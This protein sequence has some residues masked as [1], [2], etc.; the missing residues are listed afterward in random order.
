MKIGLII[1]GAGSSRRYQSKTSKLFE[2]IDGQP[3]LRHTYLAFQN[4]ATIQ[5]TIITL[6][7]DH[8]AKGQQ[9][10]KK[11]AN[12]VQLI[13]GGETRKE[14]VQNAFS[15]LNPDIDWVMIHDGARPIVSEAL[16]RRVIDATQTNSAI[17]PGLPVSDTIKRV[18]EKSVVET[19]SRDDLVTVQTPQ[20]FRKD[21]LSEAYRTPMAKEATDEA[22]L[23]EHCNRPVTI[24]PGDAKN[25]KVTYPEDLVLAQTFITGLNAS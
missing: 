24:V 9:M 16:I 12:A 10:F 19:V 23:L 8:I 13:E 5:Q 18:K 4:I 15:R 11:E 25:I 17:I 6:H 3:I 7:P 22:M 14:S 21:W 20:L 1:T 2:T